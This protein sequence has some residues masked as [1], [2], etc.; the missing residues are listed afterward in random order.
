MSS[1]LPRVNCKVKC[2]TCDD[3]AGI[4]QGLKSSLDNKIC[5]VKL[6][7]NTSMLYNLNIT[8]VHFRVSIIRIE[9]RGH[10]GNALLF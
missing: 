10:A 6:A 3:Q 4:K 7:S 8:T 2:V 5:S 9:F 1:K